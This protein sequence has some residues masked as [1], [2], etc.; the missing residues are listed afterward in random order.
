LNR[1]QQS[2]R[3]RLLWPLVA[4]SILA[5]IAIAV[6]SY[7]LASRIAENDLA[8]RYRSITLALENSSFPLTRNVLL[9]VA[10]LT[11]SELIVARFDGTVLESTLASGDVGQLAAEANRSRLSGSS[12]EMFHIQHDG[13]EYRATVFRR[14]KLARSSETPAWI[15][16]LFDESKVKA[17]LLRAVI[18]PLA[19]GL[20]TVALLTTITLLLTSRLIRRLSRLQ[21]QVERISQGEFNTTL[22]PGTPDE[23]GL[24]A[25]AVNSMAM[26]LQQMWKTL[27]QREGERLLHQVAAGLAHNLRNSLTGARMAVELHARGCAQ[28]DE[29]LKIALH[30]IEQTESYV[31][32]LLD[33]AAGK[34]GIDKPAKVVDCL[35]D[36]QASLGATANHMGKRLSW[37]LAPEINAKSV[38]DGP[39]LVAAITNLVFNAMQSGREVD[40]H[41]KSQ[42]SGQVAIDV[43]DDGPGPAPE[44]RETLFEPF[45]TTKPEGL[46]L[47]LPLV[48]R[49]AQRLGGD[50][51]WN[52][53]QTHTTFTLVAN[54]E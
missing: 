41:V 33:V 49:A 26:Q 47:G 16:V 40:V 14:T 39:S 3:T 7:V 36:V 2:L 37:H 32:R 18:A 44:V 17:T 53:N 15:I 28:D 54:V 22:A 50:V 30:E 20:S 34:Q 12:G 42:G 21:K 25:S 23:V 38:Q 52:R 1:P 8:R 13:V 29:G 51:T 46:G 11:E 10:S 43:T 45:V 35:H 27:H 9:S 31:R 5:S 4:V 24:L 48:R 19:T 6:A